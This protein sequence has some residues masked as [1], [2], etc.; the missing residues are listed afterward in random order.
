MRQKET[1]K[2]PKKLVIFASNRS[3]Y[4]KFHN[5][6]RANRT[7][8]G[9]PRLN[10]LKKKHVLENSLSKSCIINRLSR[11]IVAYSKYEALCFLDNTK[12]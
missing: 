5:E 10:F 6:N 4:N 8:K 7:F 2:T 12:P 1:L 11:R 9:F 3:T